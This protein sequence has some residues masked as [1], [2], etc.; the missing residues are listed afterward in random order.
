MTKDEAI[1]AAETFVRHKYAKVPQVVMV[2]HLTVREG[3]LFVECWMRAP[4]SGRWNKSDIW[5]DESG[6]EM[7]SLRDRWPEWKNAVIGRWTVRF[8][9]SWDTDALGMPETL[10]VRVGDSDGSVRQ[11]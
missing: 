8:F 5:A 11:L 10:A 9:M 2:S 4:G 6:A 1:L 7:A 3:R